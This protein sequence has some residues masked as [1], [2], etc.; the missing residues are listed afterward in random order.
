M[1]IYLVILCP[2]ASSEYSLFL[3]LTLTISQNPSL[4]SGLDVPLPYPF[5]HHTSGHRD[6][7]SSLTLLDIPSVTS[8]PET[9][10]L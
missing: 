8:P 9:Q 6:N 5:H 10:Q 1:G 3:S 7:S 4:L 2:L